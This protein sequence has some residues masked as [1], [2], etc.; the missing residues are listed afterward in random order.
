[1]KRKMTQNIGGLCDGEFIYDLN[2]SD[3]RYFEDFDCDYVLCNKHHDK[4][5]NKSTTHVFLPDIF[6]DINIEEFCKFLT[7]VPLET[8][9]IDF[10]KWKQLLDFLHAN[11]KYD[12][13]L[14]N[15]AL[16]A[17]SKNITTNT[18]LTIW[19]NY[20][21]SNFPSF[22]IEKVPKIEENWQFFM[23]H[24]LSNTVITAHREPLS[25]LP[26]PLLEKLST[27][28]M[29]FG[30]NTIPSSRCVDV[31]YELL[32]IG[33]NA[34][35]NWNLIQTILMDHEY[36]VISVDK[37]HFFARSA[38]SEYQDIEIVVR[39]SE[40]DHEKFVS[41][42]MPG[43]QS[44]FIGENLSIFTCGAKSIW[45]DG[46]DKPS[47]NSQAIVYLRAGLYPKDTKVVIPKFKKTRKTKPI[48]QK[49]MNSKN[50]C[51]K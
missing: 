5:E 7:N 35:D 36:I 32:C 24:N 12:E 19:Q 8:Y 41:T 33:Q 43:F 38:N 39:A 49:K 20:K 47:K 6:C 4:L 29:I 1:M 48:P 25:N 17:V 46:F 9:D 42:M 10:L 2:I 28:I 21:L 34:N 37:D 31:A 3:F 27:D 23:S 11:S 22:N 16:Q 51:L 13:L 15:I 45:N 26:K 40:N 14:K 18:I 44:G 50:K 30:E